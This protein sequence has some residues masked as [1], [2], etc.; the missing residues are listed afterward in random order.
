MLQLFLILLLSLYPINL[1]FLG[2]NL[3][4]TKASQIK[5]L[6]QKR[7]I[8][9]SYYEESLN[10]IYDIIEKEGGKKIGKLKKDGLKH[11]EN[12]SK[13][14]LRIGFNRNEIHKIINSLKTHKISSNLFRNIPVGH[15]IKFALPTNNLGIGIEFKYQKNKD[16]YIWQKDDNQLNSK[17]TKRPTK[18]MFY[19][20]KG[21]IRTNFY[22]AAKASEIPEK[23]FFEMVSI[24]SFVIDF[25]RDIRIG[26]KFEI[27]YAKELD[28]LDKKV[29]N[30][31]LPM[32]ISIN[33]SGK[34][35]SYYKYET[36]SGYSSYFDEN[37]F[38]A[39]KTLM[40]TPLNG[41]RLS[42]GYGNRKHPVLGYS[43]FHRGLDFAASTGTPVFAAGD[44]VI[45]FAGWKGSYGKF[46]RIRHNDLYKTSYAHL[47]KITK[48]KHQKVN[49]GDII[50]HVGNTGRS[51]G[52]HLHYEVI[53]SGKQVNPMKIRLPSGK[54]I[55]KKEFL[56][57][58]KH[59]N[60]I[61]KNIY[62]ISKS[63]N[64][65]N[66]LAL[67]EKRNNISK[68]KVN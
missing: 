42:S 34:K 33:N 27:F 59:I 25:Q 16:I 63:K 10:S 55:P 41:A 56:N 1:N 68:M 11:G 17:I 57:F 40:K 50:G 35:V 24:L 4:N 3:N 13:F 38:S 12:L 22:N 23:I 39:K 46:I 61:K 31:D 44:G 64:K 9:L 20:D 45:E 5:T 66:S 60:K 32:F 28:L 65:S 67:L 21:I 26:D 43:K 36:E 49:Q 18:K 29:I 15:K 30:S 52:S 37:G 51:T 47:S 7:P 58:K 14:F 6:P 48:R 62:L 19:Y 2:F 54:N 8:K 53:F